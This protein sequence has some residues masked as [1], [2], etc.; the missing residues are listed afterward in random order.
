MVHRIRTV[1][2]LTALLVL[3]SVTSALA[4]P[5]EGYGVEPY[6]IAPE[7]AVRDTAS[8]TSAIVDA[9]A[10]WSVT[11]AVVVIVVVGL[12]TAVA[13]FAAGSLR[14]RRALAH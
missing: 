6:G 13:G 7:T 14:G 4:L 1:L 12:L 8:T 11:T 3:G 2:S 10:S 9:A 5:G